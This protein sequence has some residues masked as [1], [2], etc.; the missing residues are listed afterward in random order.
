M[1]VFSIRGFDVGGTVKIGAFCGNERGQLWPDGDCPDS[2]PSIE[3]PH[4]LPA[5]EF[6]KA[7]N[8]K[9]FLAGHHPA[10]IDLCGYSICGPM[11]GNTC[12]RL[13]NRGILEPFVV[14][15]D[16]VI[17]DGLAAL[18]ASL[19]TG[20]AKEHKGGVALFTLGTGIGFGCLH[21]DSQGERVLNDGEAHFSIR[22]GTRRRCGCK[23]IGCFEAS[24]NEGALLDFAL[25]AGLS[26]DEITPNLGLKLG[27]IL[28]N[29]VSP[30]S[31]ILAQQA[32][33]N[34][35]HQLAQG[36][37]NIYTTIDLGGN[38]IQAPALFILAGSLGALVDC[39]K[40]RSFMFK[41][42]QDDPLV[43]KNFNVSRE[44]DIGNRAGGIGAAAMALANHLKRPVTEITYHNSLPC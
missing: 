23:L 5:A 19:M 41:I 11:A 3:T 17:N 2:P 44:D 22:G 34:W 38:D 25:K 32:H 40:L 14:E 43:G 8:Q 18:I 35:H 39:Y 16:A 15:A 36:L 42:F 21:W 37:A 28:A 12:L 26:R 4:S 29:Q 7:L 20:A 33:T 1:S 6:M 30:G 31:C 9:L 27:A 24:A 10:T 13:I